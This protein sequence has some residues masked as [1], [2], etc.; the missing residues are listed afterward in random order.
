LKRLTAQLYTL[1][2]VSNHDYLS[3]LVKIILVVQ[4]VAP[5][6]DSMWCDFVRDHMPR[7]G[8]QSADG[9]PLQ[10]QTLD[11]LLVGQWYD[12]PTFD[13]S[14]DVGGADANCILDHTLID[15]RTTWKHNP[16]DMSFLWQMVG[17]LL[18]D[19][20]D[21][22]EINKVAWWYTRQNILI[23]M[24]LSDFVADIKGRRVEWQAWR[25]GGDTIKRLGDNNDGDDDGYANEPDGYAEWSGANGG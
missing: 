17:Y 14:Q 4:T 1:L 9:T 7:L 6:I 10:K 23:V 12:H 8:E 25:D 2:Y 13:G 5:N 3:N 24:N 19:Y 16:L 11:N 15:I 21:H 22:Y 18:L 20:T